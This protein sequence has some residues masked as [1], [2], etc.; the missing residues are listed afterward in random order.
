MRVILTLPASVRSLPTLGC[1]AHILTGVVI[2]AQPHI[3][4]QD[5]SKSAWLPVA[6]DT[7]R[8]WLLEELL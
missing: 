6:T 3:L 7:G 1:L 5:L 4:V 2:Y 8:F